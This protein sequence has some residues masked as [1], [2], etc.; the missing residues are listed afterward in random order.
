[1]TAAQQL[2]DVRVLFAMYSAASAVLPRLF[3]IE[4]I[5]SNA[6]RSQRLVGINFSAVA[7]M[8]VW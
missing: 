5:A 6:E 4:D 2:S 7:K 3:F 8:K 1:L